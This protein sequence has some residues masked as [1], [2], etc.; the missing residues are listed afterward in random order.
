MCKI[1]NLTKYTPRAN[2]FII[3][4]SR[5]CCRKATGDLIFQPGGINGIRHDHQVVAVRKSVS[6]LRVKHACDTI[7]SYSRSS[8]RNDGYA[9]CRC[10][11]TS[12]YACVCVGGCMCVQKSGIVIQ[13]AFAIL[14]RELYIRYSWRLLCFTNLDYVP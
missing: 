2:R 9:K 13:L 3:Q 1:Q 11:E 6:C 7:G 10:M 5:R 8:V 12:K 14:P 4:H